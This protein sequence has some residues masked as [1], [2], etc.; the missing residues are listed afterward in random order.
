MNKDIKT[1][2][3]MIYEICDKIQGLGNWEHDVDIRDIVKM[4]LLQMAMYISASDGTIAYQEARVM[5]EYLDTPITPQQINEV[6]R[7]HNIYST[8][9]ESSVPVCFQI[10]VAADNMID[11]AG[12]GPEVTSSELLLKLF[13]G[14]AHEVA[15]ADGNIDPQENEDWNIYSGTIKRY[16]D[17]NLNRRKEGV[18]TGITKNSGVTAPKKDD[19][20]SAPKKDGDVSAPRKG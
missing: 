15:M 5:S 14:I 18:K 17:E 4:E 11:K 19:N 1:M 12:M 20:V 6:I 8:E 7:E 2:V 16:L 13:M 3:T 9:F 10:F